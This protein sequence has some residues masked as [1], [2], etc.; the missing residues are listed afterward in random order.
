MAV[1]ASNY[2]DLNITF[3]LAPAY[4]GINPYSA[5]GLRGT[6]RL[7]DAARGAG[8]LVRTVNGG[9]IDISA[10]QMHKFRLEVAGTDQA[11]P[12]FDGFRLGVS[13]TVDSFVELGYKTGT[14]GAPNH[15]IVPGSSRVEGNYT[16]YRPRFTMMIV[17]WQTE[18]EE[19]EAN[20]PW[21]IILEE[22]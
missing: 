1:S 4:P 15:A 3:D 17:E 5:R 18:R 2:T 9:L 6:L 13:C 11:P 12:A 21:S 14:P 16:Y 19:W 20:V 8:L 10:P 22:V 7:I